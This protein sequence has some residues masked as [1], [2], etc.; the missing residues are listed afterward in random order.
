M[1]NTIVAPSITAVNLTHKQV[2]PS[3]SET[4]TENGVTITPNGVSK[5]TINFEREED[6]IVLCL[7]AFVHDYVHDYNLGSMHARVIKGN[8]VSSEPTTPSLFQSLGIT[9]GNP[10]FKIITYPVGGHREVNLYNDDQFEDETTKPGKKMTFENYQKKSESLIATRGG[11]YI[12]GIKQPYVKNIE[13]LEKSLGETSMTVN[14]D[15]K[16]KF[17]AL[18]QGLG[19]GLEPALEPALEQ[20]LEQDLEPVFVKSVNLTD[21]SD[22]LFKPVS[23]VLTENKY[24]QVISALEKDANFL[25]FHSSLNTYVATYLGYNG[26]GNDNK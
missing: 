21:V 9:I 18:E 6:M 19:Q 26:N 13:G 10:I 16:Q 23:T 24:D 5:N 8:V 20:G 3:R 7:S 25:A 1:N 15:E 14:L 12:G 17:P 11:T 22:L 4:V 2:F